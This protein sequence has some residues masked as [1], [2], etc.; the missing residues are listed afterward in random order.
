MLISRVW[1]G[2]EC[3]I[4]DEQCGFRQATECM[5]QVCARRHVCE[6]YLSN[7]KDVFWA[8]MDLEKAYDT[9]D[10]HGMWQMQRVQ[11]VGVIYMKA[12][13]SFYV[14]SMECVRVGND[15]REPFPVN[16]LLIQ[17]C[18]MSPWLSYVYMDGVI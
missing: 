8:S 3:E 5:D 4:G 17:G 9:I 2:T 15:V 13:Q 12:V 7:G 16:V 1:A 18:M 14:D 11:G 10:L 6:K